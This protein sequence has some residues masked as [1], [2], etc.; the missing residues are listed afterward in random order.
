MTD[1][2]TLLKGV[3][4]A[5]TATEVAIPQFS[6]DLAKRRFEPYIENIEKMLQDMVELNV[7]DEGAAEIC[8]RYLTSAKGLSD[9]IEGVVSSILKEERVDEVL[10]FVDRVKTFAKQFTSKLKKIEDEGRKKYNGYLLLVE[11][12][13]REQEAKQRQLALE[14]Q[15]RINDEAKKA[16]VDPVQIPMPTIPTKPEAIRTE[17]GAAH[18]RMKWGYD[19]V[20]I[21]RIPHFFTD[22]Q[23]NRVQLL[24]DN[25]KA[26]EGLIDSGVRSI[27]GIVISEKPIA[28]FRKG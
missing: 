18:V 5:N 25:K 19:V 23:G 20:D 17:T 14:A 8:V 6:I 21:S 13:R 27:P 28:I 2:R 16:G 15:K 10:T 3:P 9:S 24:V 11:Q 22:A 1:F 7:K 4:G 26:I 12:K